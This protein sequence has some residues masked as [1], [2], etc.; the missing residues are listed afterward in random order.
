MVTRIV[1]LTVVIVT[2]GTS[3]FICGFDVFIGEYY[4]LTRNSCLEDKH[5]SRKL[6]RI[7]DFEPDRSII[8]NF[9]PFAAL[10]LW[11]SLHLP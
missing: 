6:S 11:N 4:S 10:S 9:H 3:I 8:R 5:C 1:I 2:S 7:L